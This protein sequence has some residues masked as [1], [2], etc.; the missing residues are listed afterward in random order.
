MSKMTDSEKEAGLAQVAEGF[1]PAMAERLR[2]FTAS[3][4][5]GAELGDIT[6]DHAFLSLWLRD[7][8]GKRDRSLITV[9]MLLALGHHEEL[10]IHACIA[11]ENGCTVQELE[12]LVYHATAYAGIPAASAARRAIQARLQQAGLLGADG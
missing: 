1:S 8:L 9:A 10:G 4:P 3:E 12:E 5:F 6:L 7:G 11:V 2:N